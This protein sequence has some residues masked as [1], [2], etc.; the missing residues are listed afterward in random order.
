MTET[1]PTP[2]APA[3]LAPTATKGARPL[4]EVTGL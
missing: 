2:V 4:L 3:A 1:G